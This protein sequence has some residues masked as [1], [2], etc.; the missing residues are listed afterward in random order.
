MISQNIE[1]ILFITGILT[2]GLVIQF[3]FPRIIVRNNFG[4]E[5]TGNAA[6]LMAR[7][8]AVLVFCCGALLV[9]AARHP[10]GREPI[11]VVAMCEKV[12]LAIL[13]IASPFRKMP[14][15]LIMASGDALMAAIY[16]AYLLGY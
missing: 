15:P 13:I 5:I 4:E 12:V 2:C 6:L 11:L 10:E 9:W 8:W 1:L 7:H 14:I 16:V 3:F